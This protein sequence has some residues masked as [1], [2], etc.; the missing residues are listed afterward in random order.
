MGSR[1]DACRS[2]AEGYPH[3]MAS[4]ATGA[5]SPELGEPGS[6]KETVAPARWVT[7]LVTEE[8]TGAPESYEQTYI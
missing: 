3:L 1:S 4:T 8:R 2:D 5:A 6:R 7:Q